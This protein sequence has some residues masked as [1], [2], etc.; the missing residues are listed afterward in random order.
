MHHADLCPA[1]HPW[2]EMEHHPGW[3]GGKMGY[4]TIFGRLAWY[5]I[6]ILCSFSIMN[7][8]C[9]QFV[10]PPDSQ[11]MPWLST[12]ASICPLS[13]SWLLSYPVCFL[14]T[15]LTPILG[16]RAAINGNLRRHRCPI[17]GLLAPLSHRSTLRTTSLPPGSSRQSKGC[18]D[19]WPRS[20]WREMA[21]RQPANLQLCT[22]VIYHIILERSL[23]R[24]V[25]HQAS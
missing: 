24:G 11:T 22:N 6:R 18:S 13:S 7:V 4:N 21:A 23:L 14:L 17:R 3:S 16:G 2:D 1:E 10:C 25:L 8:E 12:R 20:C 9:K 15:T 19:S 5:F